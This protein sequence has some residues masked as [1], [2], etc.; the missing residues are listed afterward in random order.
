MKLGF[1]QMKQI[2][3]GI[4]RGTVSKV[5]IPNPVNIWGSVMYNTIADILKFDHAKL[6]IH[7]N[8][9]DK[10]MSHLIEQNKLH[11]HQAF[12]T[13]FATPAMQRCIGKYGTGKGAKDILVGD[14]DLNI[15]ENLPA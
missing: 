9:P 8:D 7:I 13:S 5:Y 6:Y 15:Q 14:F 12:N 4:T 2:T 10:V 11:L 1:K 3:K